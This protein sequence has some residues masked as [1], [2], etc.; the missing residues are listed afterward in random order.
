MIRRL[1]WPDRTVLLAVFISRSFELVALLP[2]DQ[3]RKTRGLPSERESKAGHRRVSNEIHLGTILI[4][5]LVVML[6]HVFLVL[7]HPP[8]LR[9]SLELHPLIDRERRNPD[10][11]HAEVIRA[12]EV[13]SLRPCI[14]TDRQ[15]E[16]LR[17]RFNI[18]IEVGALRPG[19]LHFL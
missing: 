4:T 9:M 18:G 3:F 13:R 15:P 10:S 7:V 6:L 8:R 14:R 1:R 5:R 12:V 19:N 17:C 16:L 11:R 2:F